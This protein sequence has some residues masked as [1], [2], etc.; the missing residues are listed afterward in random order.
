MGMLLGIGNVAHQIYLAVLELLQKFRP[1][2][3]YVL[4][5]P[6]CIRRKL[7]LILIRITRSSSVFICDKI[8]ASCHPTRMTFCEFF[9]TANA[10]I[11]SP[12]VIM[13]RQMTND[14][15]CFIRKYADRYSL[16]F[17][18]KLSFQVDFVVNTWL[19]NYYTII[20][21]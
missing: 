4:I 5:F 1:G 3:F 14:A 13:I 6:A 18:A 19:F 7:P 16:S 9:F 12:A 8:G 2:A 17:I 11:G 21:I 20:C 10:E 15:I